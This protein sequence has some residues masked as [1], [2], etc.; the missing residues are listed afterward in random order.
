MTR[1]PLTLAAS[2]TVALPGATVVRT[3]ALSTGLSGRFDSALVE[4]DDGR[5]VVVRASTDESGATELA[6]ESIALRALTPGVRALLPFRAPEFHGEAQLPDG[7]ILATGWVPGYAVE[8]AELP[9]GPGAAT[10]L[11]IALAALHALPHS[12]VRAVGLPIRT[13]ADARESVRDVIERADATHHLPVTLATRWR[14]AVDD[15]L[16]WN[17]EPTVILGDASASSFR[18]EDRNDIPTVSGVLGWQALAVGDPAVDLHWLV[19]AP[20]ASEDVL[21]TYADSAS[22]APDGQVSVRARL[23]AEL[24]FAKWLIHGHDQ[25]RDDIVDDAV[26][27]LDA[28]VDGLRE[29]AP[30]TGAIATVDPW[31]AGGSSR[32]ADDEAENA[33]TSMQTD[34]YDPEMLSLFE[35]KEQEHLAESDADAEAHVVGVDLTGA[36]MQETVPFDV[37]AW[38]E[39]EEREQE[40][41]EQVERK[42]RAREQ[43]RGPAAASAGGSAPSASAATSDTDENATD[44][45]DFRASEAS[46]PP[47]VDATATPDTDAQGTG[48]QGTGPTATDSSASATSGGEA[49]DAERVPTDDEIE[50]DAERASRAA[51]QRWASSP[52]E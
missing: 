4:L 6:A 7:R 3:A 34:A 26:A 42:Q 5:R 10:S 11:G 27:L 35:A 17:F 20:E 43:D 49:Q 39:Q 29:A 18:Y 13:A 52:S 45:Y 16:L 21:A 31:A 36:E 30:L 47:A 46:E 19:A 14:A 48:A 32:D 37:A 22:R 51:L 15:D 50:R 40:E 2:V 12:V 23:Y 24:E 1:S 28:L 38:R 25:H 33:S 41:R 44:A 8:T 9:A